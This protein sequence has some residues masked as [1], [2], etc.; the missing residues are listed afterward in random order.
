MQATACFGLIFVATGEKKTWRIVVFKYVIKPRISWTF[1]CCDSGI[2]SLSS[3]FV[4]GRRQKDFQA[5]SAFLR[6]LTSLVERLGKTFSNFSTTEP[7]DWSSYVPCT[8][9]AS[10]EGNLRTTASCKRVAK[11]TELAWSKWVI[12]NSKLCII[13]RV[14]LFIGVY[15][16]FPDYLTMIRNNREDSAS[17]L[18]GND[19]EFPNTTRPAKVIRSRKELL[20]SEIP[21]GKCAKLRTVAASNIEFTH[22]MITFRIRYC[23]IQSLASPDIT[24]HDHSIAACSRPTYMYG[25]V[26]HAHPVRGESH[27]QRNTTGEIATEL[28]DAFYATT[29]VSSSEPS[30]SERM[31]WGVFGTHLIFYFEKSSWQRRLL[32]QPCFRASEAIDRMISYCS[33]IFQPRFGVYVVRCFQRRH[34]FVPG[35]TISKIHLQENLE[36]FHRIFACVYANGSP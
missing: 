33:L 26:L 34:L 24:R 21:S 19:A 16:T 18:P 25:V 5:R 32:R 4:F 9:Q 12:F 27:I 8:K 2:C 28:S 29:K 36:N 10:Q 23:Y 7:I 31:D 17:K 14:I 20:R 22:A 13:L 15:S 1:F 3:S 35:N 11:R 6:K 30:R